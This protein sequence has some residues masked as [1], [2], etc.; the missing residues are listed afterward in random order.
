MDAAQQFRL[1]GSVPAPKPPTGADFNMLRDEM[2]TNKQ[3]EMLLACRMGIS[4]LHALL[5]DW[6]AV[7]LGPGMI[8][9][10]VC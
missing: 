3:L 8:A 9:A 7:A 4:A 1:L 2:F 6:S 5:E 10:W